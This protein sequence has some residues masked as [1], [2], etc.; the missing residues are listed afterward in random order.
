MIS[1]PKQNESF[2]QKEISGVTMGVDR[3]DTGDSG[4][5]EPP[6]ASPSCL[7][8][9]DGLE[10]WMDFFGLSFHGVSFQDSIRVDF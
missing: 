4:S 3:R 8:M 2:V 7:G 10:M 1:P 9:P 6:G 5:V